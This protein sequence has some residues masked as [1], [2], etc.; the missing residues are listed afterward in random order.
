MRRWQPGALPAATMSLLS[1][2]NS[3]HHSTPVRMHLGIWPL[4]TRVV[5]SPRQI[6]RIDPTRM[7][8][9]TVR[10]GGMDS[11]AKDL[12]PPPCVDTN[13]RACHRLTTRSTGI[14]PSATHQPESP[15]RKA[16]PPRPV[17]AIKPYKPYARR[18]RTLTNRQPRRPSSGVT[19]RIDVR[20]CG[21][22]CSSSLFEACIV[23][24]TPSGTIPISTEPCSRVSGWM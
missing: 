21:A 22:S 7:R 5:A 12:S 1:S 15:G 2:Q 19:E 14:R 18:N 17:L 24:T 13:A 23:V 20:Y 10:G 6:T 11:T 8:T 4:R 3:R 16:L 9:L